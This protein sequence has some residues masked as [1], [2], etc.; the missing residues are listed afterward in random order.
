MLTPHWRAALLAAALLPGLAA[1]APLTLER[2]L[3]LA[4]QH[5]ATTR[6]A[7]AGTLSA[8]E[9]ARAAGQ[10]PDPVLT[11]GIDNLPITGRDRLSTTADGMTM[12]RIGVSQEWLSADKRAAQRAAARA[13][14]D[15]EA[16]A[17]RIAA[18]ETRLQAALAYVDTFYAAQALALADATE[19]HSREEF[20]AARARLSTATGTGQEALAMSSARG[21][22][23]DEAA[24]AR[25]VQRQAQVQLQRWLGEPA[26]R[27]ESPVFSAMPEEPAFVASHP[28]VLAAQ[29]EADLARQEA[30][31]TQANRR[32]NWTWAASYGQRT[33]YSD[34][35]SVS[36][37]IPIPVAPSHRQDRETAAK[38][39][40]VDR[41]EANLA[42]AQRAAT[43]EYRSLEADAERLAERVQR[44]QASVIEPSRQRTAAALAGYRSS[45]TALMSLFEARHA[46]L[47]AQRKLLSLQRDLAR[48]RAQL[49][50]KPVTEGGAP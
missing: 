44:Y 3:D 40:L 25:Q 46:E 1:A 36:V 39:A 47:L 32:P 9:A 17:A 50:F 45:Q 12:K 35:V 23:E 4:V 41:A 21:A 14:V 13:G 26:D 22:A 15:R 6:A 7:Q 8:T 38:L 20:E 49:A 48:T 42:E 28:A 19:H 18:A 29:R 37:S 5:S 43:A 16:A 31:L 27:L 33:G 30:S 10:L 11:A 34:M 24:E 2:A